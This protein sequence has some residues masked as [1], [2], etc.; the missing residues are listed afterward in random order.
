MSV[1]FIIL[2]QTIGFLG[3]GK[4]AVV[5]LTPLLRQGGLAL[6]GGLEKLESTCCDPILSYYSVSN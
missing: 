4:G 2:L 6:S 5:S 3:F 1:S